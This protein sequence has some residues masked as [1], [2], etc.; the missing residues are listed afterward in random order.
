MADTFTVERSTVVN[1]PAPAI[2]A[3]INDFHRWTD[4]SP[5]EGMDPNLQRTYAGPTSGVGSSYGWQGNRKV[6]AGEMTIIAT[7][8]QQVDIE[9]N[10]LRPFKASNH[11]VFALVP[12]GDA[13]RITWTMTGKK[14]LM[15]KVMGLFMN[16][17]RLIGRDFEKGLAALKRVSE[18]PAST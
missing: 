1:A 7:A 9:L 8:P 13:T 10:F 6:G 15:S 18:K 5:W 3:R 14:T 2:H 12:E 4:W 11:T 17:D 16:M